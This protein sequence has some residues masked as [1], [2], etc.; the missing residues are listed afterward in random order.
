MSNEKILKLWHSTDFPSA[1]SNVQYFAKSLKK[2]NKDLSKNKTTSDIK[3]ILEN[4]IYYQTS[5]NVRKT[6]K[7]R[8][9]LESYFSTR[10]EADLF[11]IGK[12]RF[13]DVTSGSTKGRYGLLVVDVFSKTI[14]IK[15]LANKNAKDV[16]T[17][18]KSILDNFS[19]PFSDPGKFIAFFSCPFSSL[20]AFFICM[21]VC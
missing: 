3:K 9:D 19:P 7:T 14:F 6:F 2:K 21:A 12:D 13:I 18:F 17:A 20:I 8:N 15:P 5:R 4:D 1:Y 10:M 16:L 11:D